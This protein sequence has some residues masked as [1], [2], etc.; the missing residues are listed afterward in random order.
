MWRNCLQCG[1]NF[2]TY[3]AEEKLCSPRCKRARAT[4][5]EKI[6]RRRKGLLPTRKNRLRLTARQ[7]QVLQLVAEGK[8]SKEVAAALNITVNTAEKHRA[9]IMRRLDC[10]SVAMTRKSGVAAYYPLT[11]LMGFST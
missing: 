6:R 3:Y 4:W 2:Q 11:A 7:T 5:R 8:R 1:L 10:H 9:N